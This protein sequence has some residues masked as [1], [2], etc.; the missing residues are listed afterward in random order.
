MFF[1]YLV[2]PNELVA[3][4]GLRK[5]NNGSFERTFL[6]MEK[7][8]T[9]ANKLE[10]ENTCAGIYFA[11]NP[12]APD[13]NSNFVKDADISRRSVLFIDIDPIKLPANDMKPKDVSSNEE[14]LKATQDLGVEVVEWMASMGVT[15]EPLVAMSGNGTHIF[16][17][18]DMENTEESLQ[19]IHL[20]LKALSD[21]FTGARGDLDVKVKNA[22]RICKVTGT[23]ARKGIDGVEA[24][25]DH[26]MASVIEFPVASPED[27]D[28]DP[29]DADVIDHLAAQAVEIVKETKTR[30]AADRK[31]VS[32]GGRVSE[33][34]PREVSSRK[35]KE[36]KMTTTY[37]NRNE[38]II[39]H[40]PIWIN[41]AYQLIDSPDDRNQWL[42]M[43]TSV[44]EVMG[45]NGWSSFDAWC[46]KS[47]S[48]DAN[49]NR[50]AWDSPA[51]TEDIASESLKLAYSFIKAG[52]D[53]DA[54]AEANG[55]EL[56]KDDVMSIDE[57]KAIIA[58]DSSLTVRWSWSTKT[59]AYYPSGVWSKDFSKRR[60]KSMS[61]PARLMAIQSILL[62]TE[63]SNG[64]LR[65]I[66]PFIMTGTDDVYVF[67]EDFAIWRHL[68]SQELMKLVVSMNGVTEIGRKDG[69]AKTLNLSDA[70]HE[71]RGV[72]AMVRNEGKMASK[73][74]AFNNTVLV[75]D[76]QTIT[77]RK[78]RSTDML[79]SKMDFDFINTLS[80]TPRFDSI[81]DR[82]FEGDAERAECYLQWAGA[83]IMGAATSLQIPMMLLVSEVGGTGK[84][85]LL[86]LMEL[87]IG[88]NN[89]FP[90]Q[91][92]NLKDR[93]ILIGMASKSMVVDYDINLD[94]ILDNVDV[95]KNIITGEGMTQ[96][97]V[98]SKTTL[99][100][101]YTGAVCGAANGTPSFKRYD[102]GLDRR[103]LIVPTTNKTF[104]SKEVMFN[105][106]SQV[107]AEEGNGIVVK[108]I[109]AFER[110][111][112]T[113]QLSIPRVC[114][115]AKDQFRAEV[116]TIS[117]FVS[118]TFDFNDTPDGERMTLKDLYVEY[119]VWCRNS[120]HFVPSRT[121]F[122]K[123]MKTKCAIK[124]IEVKMLKGYP[125]IR[126]E[127]KMT[128]F[129]N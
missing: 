37:I 59:S 10:S 108:M 105:Y 19:K 35:S 63:D 118:E 79:I 18:I 28:K 101:R 89:V 110:L 60:M 8:I 74:L 1:S 21:N 75:F 83:A 106:E 27:W 3:I 24:G 77:Q 17:R 81:I 76:G 116:D 68:T 13:Y 73:K 62:S 115:E 52:V 128:S 11:V 14:E 5:N 88:S 66:E 69:V 80:P 119:T 104:N 70:K 121:T 44:K 36:S 99:D 15:Q 125:S 90:V 23:W 43:L 6:D 50:A 103:I 129:A 4:R 127:R 71:I 95:L 120:G 85:M 25:R 67:D 82:L 78:P 47:A 39:N 87:I 7:A 84:S 41:E 53:L 22:S 96:R 126:L 38:F 97:V 86:K 100:V 112:V 48:Y 12:I 123:Q 31:A 9:Y 33:Y 54:I 102:S 122:T 40:A 34:V 2:R 117:T 56:S 61:F 107:F 109:Q 65:V 55:F 20:I 114:Q 94:C 51:R 29:I 113:R 49:N 26:R 64:F 30:K 16:Y 45:E 93:G 58:A 124:G 32:R 57:I 111:L 72:L 42:G 91:L 98:G 46:A 92:G